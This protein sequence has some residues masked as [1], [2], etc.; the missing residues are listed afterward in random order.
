MS[1]RFSQIPP[2]RWGAE[3]AEAFIRLL[4]DEDPPEPEEESARPAAGAGRCPE[5]GGFMIPAGGCRVC[6]ACGWEACGW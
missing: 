4:R 3:E 6:P 2:S 1:G 5:C